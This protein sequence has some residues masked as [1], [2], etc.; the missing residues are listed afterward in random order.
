MN[1]VIEVVNDDQRQLK[2]IGHISYFL[3]AIVAVGAVLPSYQPG[4][5]MTD[6]GERGR[7]SLPDYAID[8]VR[9]APRDALEGLKRPPGRRWLSSAEVGLIAYL[10]SKPKRRTTAKA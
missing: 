6:L 1:D 8:A 2:T 5:R 9:E 3:H 7:S 4:V 10:K